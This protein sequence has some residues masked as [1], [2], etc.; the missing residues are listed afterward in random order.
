MDTKEQGR[1]MKWFQAYYNE[2]QGIIEY[3][4]ECIK[5]D[6]EQ[7]VKCSECTSKCE[8]SKR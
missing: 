4:G 7:S 1:R 6:K 2:L 3:Y 5:R 8:S